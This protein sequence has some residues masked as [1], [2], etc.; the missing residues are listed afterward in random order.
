MLKYFENAAK[1]V[2]VPRQTQHLLRKERFK[3]WFLSDEELLAIGLKGFGRKVLVD[4]TVRFINP[5]LISIG[6][7]VRI[8]FN[9]L[10]SAGLE[11]IEIGSHVH[12]S[13][14]VQLFGG[15]GRIVLHEFSGLSPGVKLFTASD[16]FSDGWLKGPQ[17][18]IAYRKIESGGIF[19]DM[20]SQVGANS[21]VLPGVT[22]G[23]NS[24][25]GALCL[26]SSDVEPNVLVAG[27]P[28]R[29][30]KRRDGDLATKLMA[31]FR[32]EWNR[33]EQ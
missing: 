19:L 7:N 30:V 4:K 5:T 8:D 22:F 15:G 2:D 24:C 11:G 27:N 28:A 20:N 32:E 6:D 26:V 13:A 9:S 14:N 16:D 33:N 23:F 21:V 17:V 3:M 10:I 12:I 1:K 25:A 29:I 18:G 31:E